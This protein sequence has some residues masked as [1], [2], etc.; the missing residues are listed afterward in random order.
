M[1]KS[2]AQ[3][4]EIVRIRKIRRSDVWTI[5]VLIAAG[6]VLMALFIWWF[7]RPDHIGNAFIF[8][9]LTSALSFKL[10]KMLHEWY[11]YWAPSIPVPPALSKKYTV[12]ILTTSCPGEPREMIIRTL[13]AMQK[14]TYP[15]T[16]YLCDE[17]DDLVLKK[18]C[19]ELNVVHVTRAVKTDAKAGNINNALKQ[20]SGEICVV[21]DP[22]HVP[23]PEFLDRTLP[24]FEDPE[25]GYVQCVQGYSNQ[26]ESIIARGAAEQTYHFYGPM[27][28]CMN[29]YNT[30]QAIG[31][32]CTF[33]RAALDSIGGHAA[34]LSEDMH[35]AMQL[36]AKGWKSVYIPEIL[37]RGLV[38]ATLSSYYKQQ[39][40]WSRGTF[41]L[42]F[43]VYPKLFR[44][45]TWRQKVHY[46]LLPMYFLFGLVNFIDILVPIL[47]LCFAEVPW[48]ID[49]GEFGMFFLP[50]CGASLVIRLYAQR[51]LLEKHERG[52]QLAG[53]ILRTATWW[54]FLVGF[55]YSIFNIRV[56]YIPTPKE[57]EHRDY[58]KLSLP[59]I[60]VLLLCGCG[61]LY[62]LHIDWSPYSFAMAFYAMLNAAILGC[63]VVLSQQRSIGVIL[64]AINSYRFPKYLYENARMVVSKPRGWLYALM[65]NGAVA[66]S[67]ALAMLFLS[68]SSIYDSPGER[69]LPGRKEIGGFFTGSWTGEHKKKNENT[70]GNSAEIVAFTEKWDSGSPLKEIAEGQ[71]E[72][73]FINWEP[74][75]YSDSAWQYISSG[76][77]DAYLESFAKKLREY[78]DPVFLAF[79]PGFNT[80][81]QN[82]SGHA[83]VSAWQYM[84]TFFN[85]LGISNVTW[86][87]SP[88]SADAVAYYPG[89]KFVDWIGVSCLNYGTAVSD[90]DNYSFS[91]LYKPF[92]SK[93]GMFQKPFI[94]REF[95][96]AAGSIQP[97]WF[98]QA[99]ADIR[100][101][102]REVQ[103][104]VLYEGNKITKTGSGTWT[105]VFSAENEATMAEL[106]TGFSFPEFKKEVFL[107][108]EKPEQE[109][110]VYH[111]AFV[112]GKPGSFV[113]NVH[114]KPVYIKGVAYN[115]AHDWRDGNMPL[116]RRQ[117]EKDMEKIREMGAN[118]IRRY[119]HG[120][121][122]RNVLNIAGEYGLNVMYGFWFDPEVDY[123]KDSVRVKEY[124]EMVEEKVLQF[125]DH[126]SVI[127]WAL[128]NETWGLLKH[129]YSKPY[130]TKVRRSYLQMVEQMAQR[131]HELDPSRPV[132]SC[133][134][135]ERYQLPGELAAFYDEVPSLDMIGVNTYYEE[136]IASLNHVFY[137]F[138]SIRPYLVSEFGP[139]GYWDPSFN[140]TSN[141]LLKEDSEEEKS[142]WYKRQWK[143]YVNAYRGY[144]V[145]GVAYCWH[146]RMEGSNTWFGITDYRGRT[147]PVY[148]ALKEAWTDRKEKSLPAY[149]IAFPDQLECGHEYV[150]KVVGPEA[151]GRKLHYQWTLNKDNYLDAMDVLSYDEEEPEVKVTIPEKRSD[152]RLYLYVSDESGN[153][154][155]A[156]VALKVY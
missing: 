15:H 45:F 20:A 76:K 35:T 23:I 79:A 24:Y 43:R 113:L 54:I 84:Y 44:N 93:L 14:I 125:K 37:T 62:G 40:K 52:L 69:K 105:S 110:A 33:R 42:L 49:L 124:M 80:K 53:G 58:W 107:K 9:L 65:R 116:T 21:L 142:G 112:S 108:N 95:G 152:Y 132:I 97:G 85:N 61:A 138:D 36:H 68:Y 19:E 75:V 104:L 30:V 63:I 50:L 100:K 96:C 72:M 143:E 146:D 99:F 118:T 66:L 155:T 22:D 140:R 39:L 4:D 8:W 38:P 16:S 46:F 115:T 101:D 56:P 151:E 7:V 136:Q 89:T 120:I 60:G 2:Y 86:V 149:S 31:A 134:E 10:L 141:G 17:G 90:N 26:E 145:G 25:I 139:R 81:G 131:I 94:I 156:S 73:P 98:K 121:Y 144:N 18:V 27:M 109:R 13:E 91:Q 51:W 59:N 34:G 102:F 92:R 117:V 127:A 119:D 64:S 78:H 3:A 1:N 83:F 153:V 70:L 130:L 32:N 129:N 135:H 74:E 6:L 111:S 128:G 67:V 55:I 103:G 12:D 122:D 154:S 41:E 82:N 28:M 148:Y 150:F 29:T 5:R 133:I 114:G 87:W 147:K 123:Y 71:G 77:A 11:H 57:D 126:S 106:K 47:A 48:E 88:A 137:Q